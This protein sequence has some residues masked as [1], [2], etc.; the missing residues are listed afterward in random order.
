MSDPLDPC[1]PVFVNA[2]CGLVGYG[3]QCRN[4]HGAIIGEDYA[5]E[6]VGDQLRQSECNVQEMENI[7][8][9]GGEAAM[10]RIHLDQA[11][12]EDQLA[13]IRKNPAVLSAGLFTIV[14]RA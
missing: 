13:A 11:P 8:Y 14:R 1:D 2:A 5:N 12:S 6:G 9:E 3:R 4:S 7:I 10:A